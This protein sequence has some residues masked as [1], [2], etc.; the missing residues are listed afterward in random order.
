MKRQRRQSPSPPLVLSKGWGV[1]AR[2]INK[3][4]D[5]ERL[6]YRGISVFLSY[7][8]LRSL[9]VCSLLFND[10]NGYRKGR[11]DWEERGKMTAGAIGRSTEPASDS[12]REP[13]QHQPTHEQRE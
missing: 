6:R 8:R 12:Q 11:L 9:L 7:H 5:L 2:S 13:G 3:I 10:I 1:G 4:K